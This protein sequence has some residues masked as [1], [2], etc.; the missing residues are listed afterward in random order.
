MAA[1]VP[2]LPPPLLY[3]GQIGKG[4]HILCVFVSRNADLF[5]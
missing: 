5:L 4:N 1:V 2:A 3:A